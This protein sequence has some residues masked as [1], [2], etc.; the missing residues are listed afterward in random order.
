[1]SNKLE[2]G[3][4]LTN[5]ANKNYGWFSTLSTEEQA[6][7][8]PFVVMQFL[9]SAT[10]D[11]DYYIVAVNEYLNKNFSIIS[12]NKDLFYRICC[13][14]GNGKY[15]KTKFIRPPK[16]R[17]QGQSKISVL[18]SELMTDSYSDDLAELF[19]R[20]NPDYETADWLELAKFMEWSKNDIVKLEKELKQI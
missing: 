6:A 18:V 16:G 2:I 15:I 3:T 20:K 10:T 9:S 17:K 5:I 8:E 13:V 7:F 1:M 12:R 4:V 11:E 14:I 19:I